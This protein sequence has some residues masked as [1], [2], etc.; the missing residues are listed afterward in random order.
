MTLVTS[1]LSIL[2]GDFTLF[3]SRISLFSIV[4][5]RQELGDKV[6]MYVSLLAIRKHMPVI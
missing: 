3:N 6:C 2:L 1:Q 4:Y 5:H